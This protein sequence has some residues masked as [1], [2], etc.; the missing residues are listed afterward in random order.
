MLFHNAQTITPPQRKERD[1]I[2]N[3]V[4]NT[5]PWNNLASVTVCLVLLCGVSVDFDKV[6]Y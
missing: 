2:S 5:M 1:K 6:I 4:L 3:L